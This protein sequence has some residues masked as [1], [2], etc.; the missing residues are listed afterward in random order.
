M[1]TRASGEPIPAHRVPGDYRPGYAEARAAAPELADRYVAHTLVGDP[2]ADALM[3]HLAALERDE[4]ARLL[5]EGIENP[6]GGALVDAHPPARAFFADANAAPP[7]LD[8]D[9][10]RPAWR[11]FHRNTETVLGGLLAG[12]LVEG[13]A[14]NISKSFFITGRLRDQGAR[15]L[16]QNNRHMMEIFLP[17][18]LERRG[19]GWKL[20]VRLRLVHAQV[21]YLL[22]NS[23]QWDAPAWGEPVSAAHLGFAISAFS[24]RL[25]KHMKSLGASYDETER[26]SFMQVW[27]YTGHLMGVPESMLFRDEA[28]ALR[29][30][31][32]GLQCEPPP[33]VESAVMAHA[34]INSAP[35]IVGLSEPEE[36]RRMAR[37]IFRISRA[38]VGSELADRLHYPPARSFGAL[39]W[40]RLKRGYGRLVAKAFPRHGAHSDFA[41]FA[42]LLAAAQYDDAGISYDLPDHVYAEESSRY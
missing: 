6:E 32:V 26:A 13:F 39:P 8:P 11:M 5:R 16:R 12:V 30:F 10:F 24:A 2:V 1:A 35:L 36:R 21:R 15:R 3:D 42:N 27:R 23:D 38:L 25:L 7:W 40:Y 17:D 22:R 33:G 29:L 14:T 28:E 31:Q 4:A 9:A 37:Y 20:S 18:G 19:D 41:H 34:L